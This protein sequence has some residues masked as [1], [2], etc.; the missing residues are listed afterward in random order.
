[1]IPELG[2][3]RQRQHLYLCSHP[4][5]PQPATAASQQRAAAPGWRCRENGS[6]VATGS[7][8]WQ[9]ECP[10]QTWSGRAPKGLSAPAGITHLPQHPA[11]GVALYRS[12]PGATG[13]A[14]RGVASGQQG[15]NSASRTLTALSQQSTCHYA[16]DLCQAAAVQLAAAYWRVDTKAAIFMLSSRG[17]DNLT[18]E[19]SSVAPEAGMILMMTTLKQAHMQAPAPAPRCT[20]DSVGR[21]PAG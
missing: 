5:V 9:S 3:P 15:W 6:G 14:L 13:T 21:V 18:D 8:G 7:G 16:H 11:S 4:P 10:E 2:S 17:R 12:G 19:Q 20:G 1:M